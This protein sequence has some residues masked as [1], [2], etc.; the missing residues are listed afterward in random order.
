MV[1]LLF[2]PRGNAALAQTS[3][4][5]TNVAGGLWSDSGN[6]SGGTIADGTGATASFT[7]DI[8]AA[9]T[10]GLDS[11]RT[12]GNLTFNDTVSPS[13]TTP[14]LLDNNGDVSNI[15]TLDV[16]S[17][18][19]TITVGTSNRADVSVTLA[20]TQ[21]LVKAGGGRLLLTGSNSYS[22][23]TTLAASS[24][25]LVLG[26]AQA[27]GGST[28]VEVTGNTSGVSVGNGVSAGAGATITLSGVANGF[29]NDGGLTAINSSGTWAGNVTLTNGRLGYREGNL[30]I[31]GT[32]GGG[33][34]VLSGWGDD[35]ENTGSQYG[36]TLAGPSTYSG[37]TGLLRGWL[38][39]GRDD[40]LPTGTTLDV[41]TTANNTGASQAATFDLNGFNQTVAVLQ[42]TGLLNRNGYANGYVTN[43][44]LTSGTLTVNQATSGT[45]RGLLTG[46]V[47]LVKSGAG[48]LTLGPV[49]VTTGNS[50]VNGTNSFTG[51]TRVDGGTLTLSSGTTATSL[52]LFGSTFDTDGAGTLAIASGITA[53]TFGGLAGSGTLALQTTAA[54]AVALSV[55]GGNASSTFAGRLTGPGSL[56]KIGSG[57]LTLSGA[58]SD[59]AGGTT[60]SAGTL[61]VTNT[62]AIPGLLD[63]G[64]YS[65]AAGA[66]LGVTS[67]I[68][69][70]SIQT[71]FATDNF[72][73]GGQVA[74][75]TSAGGRQ[76]AADLGG[77]AGLRTLG[78]NVLTLSGSNGFTGTTTLTQG[79]VELASAHALAGSGTIIFSGGTL[80]YAAA[81][82][83]ADISGRIGGSGA[84]I[85]VDTNGQTVAFAS[86]IASG[87]TGGLTK[88]GAGT[89]VLSGTNAYSG[90]TTV[91]GGTLEVTTTNFWSA[92]PLVIGDAEVGFNVSTSSLGSS[93]AIEVTGAS[94]VRQLAGGNLTMNSVISGTGSLAYR[95]A[96][97]GQYLVQSGNTYSGGTVID[98]GNV[99]IYQNSALDD[100]LVT[101]GVLGSGTLTLAAG[102]LRSNVGTPRTIANPVRITGD[103]TL[104][105]AGNNQDFTFTGPATLVGGDH[106][107]TVNFNNNPGWT[108]YF[109]AG[110]IGEDAPGRGLTKAGDGTLVLAGTNT[111]SG[112]TTVAAGTLT[113][114]T[115]A[116]L[117][118]ATTEG[119]YSVAAGG[120]L[121]TTA[122]FDDATLEAMLGTGNFAPNS[123]LGV[124]TGAGDRTFASSISGTIRLAVTGGNGLTL[125]GS[126][127][128]GAITVTD[129]MLTISNTA[130][131]L[132][133]GG[134]TVNGGE[135]TWAPTPSASY[136]FNG[137]GITV[138]GSGAT[139]RNSSTSQLTF[140]NLSGTGA[141]IYDAGPG[142]L[143]TNSNSYTGGTTIKPGAIIAYT[144]NNGF[145][146]GP[147]TIEGGSLRSSQGAPRTISN[148]VSLAGDVTF[149][150][151]GSAV[152]NNLV[153]S[154]PMTIT[155]TTRT[156]NVEMSP[157]PDATGIFFNGPIGDGGNGYGLVKTGTSKL[158]L[159]GTN[160]YTGPTTVSAGRL[161]VDGS[162]AASSGVSVSS[163][164]ELGGTGIVA[165]IT[166]A[167]VVAP[168]NSAGILTSPSADLSGGLGFAFE[169]AQA[170]EPTWSAATASGNDVLRLTD[171][172][173]P[174]GGTATSTNVFDIYFL[175]TNQTYLG[176]LFTDLNS[177]F[178][179][180]VSAATFNYFV[181]DAA[182]PIT[183]EGFNYAALSDDNVTR[184][185]V[186]VASADFAGGTVTNGYTMQFVVVPEP[187]AW[188][189]AG[190]GIAAAGWA[191]RRKPFCCRP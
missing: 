56:V 50:F 168:G 72:T 36:V 111:Y 147:V 2:A 126:N 144:A 18:T 1:V 190:L 189:L 6:W 39:L 137:R 52:A 150:A 167:G 78:G 127:R 21:G 160:T 188:L 149:Y 29:N 30:V 47:S 44:A 181:R 158:I 165:A 105:G 46:N 141:V 22:G 79:V 65:V 119:R 80:R 10:I 112:T 13:F 117:P 83:A 174:L 130:G 66:A 162:I 129:A 96:G 34:F 154:G 38:R 178:E 182:G 116:A 143:I 95:T 103:F 134:I 136:S 110:P 132:G 53:A 87:N 59:Y 166:G 9:T 156:V 23:T 4:T 99:V 108:G 131:L 122:A 68:D 45:Y 171:P 109:F 70:A 60:V 172:T 106:T 62:A 49:F 82:T 17:G 64:S 145:G 67:G 123:T 107:L 25:L 159:G 138:T 177:S 94:A 184:L 58:T 161:A 43:T 11:I 5:W 93:R 113:I 32:V 27:L 7:S 71:I 81:G 74:I 142:E 140:G 37:S 28:V 14:W 91:S 19:P 173:T 3:S 15:L 128:L 73:G 151:S 57:T 157:R 51:T 185:T 42:S 101:G 90:P 24:G 169:F 104:A 125:S 133:S 179:G 41:F 69:D 63:S 26:H 75:D 175:E 61:L 124:D 84:A 100:G 170:G 183:Y 98:G 176:G 115:A 92:G 85:L 135:V 186:Q 76:V 148:T 155:G 77:T 86:S 120:T 180:L 35:K 12:I 31:T 54:G 48:N 102:S 146:P 33:N 55:G 191:V 89:L 114:A 152:D 163:G 20:G 88:S 118:G 187:S 8:T 164:A 121:A 16:A 153:F 97:G 40:A 139:F